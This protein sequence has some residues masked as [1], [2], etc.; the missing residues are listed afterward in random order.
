M[1]ALADLALGA[2]GRLVD[3]CI[4]L[5]V[6]G[7]PIGPCRAGLERRSRPRPGRDRARYTMGTHDTGNLGSATGMSGHGR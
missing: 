2:G 4:G 3:A 7:R 6:P 1:T 5:A